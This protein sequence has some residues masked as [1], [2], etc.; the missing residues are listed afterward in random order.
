M[1]FDPIRVVSRRK[2]N[3]LGVHFGVEFPSGHVVDIT[4][5]Q[6]Y[7][8]ISKQAFA[9]GEVVTVTQE[10]PWN[11][12]LFVRGRLDELRRNPRKYDLLNWNCETFAEYLV[13]GVAKSTQAV[14]LL[15]LVGA[16]IAFA[17]AARS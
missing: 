17:I 15:L 7:R 12:G 4:I 9:D 11:Q 1:I 10:I 2:K 6:G 8:Q 3:G 13:S 5:D 16:A 14:G